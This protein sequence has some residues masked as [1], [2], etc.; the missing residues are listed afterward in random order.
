MPPAISIILPTLNESEN[1]PRIVPRIAEALAGRS[2]EILVIDDD[3]E[4]ATRSVCAELAER[5]PLTLH[6]R[7]QPKDGL[8]GA[9]LEVRQ[10][11]VPRIRC[12]RQER[13]DFVGGNGFCGSGNEVEKPVITGDAPGRQL[14]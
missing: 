1:L 6:V 2:Y 10:E 7:T 8:S 14:P 5:F 11:I 3:S 12:Y 13:G 9:V 4:D